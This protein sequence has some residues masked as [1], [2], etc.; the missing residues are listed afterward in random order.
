MNE[1]MMKNKSPSISKDL[2]FIVKLYLQTKIESLKI[3]SKSYFETNNHLNNDH[4]L[5]QHKNDF[6][7]HL[8]VDNDHDL[9]LGFDSIRFD[10]QKGKQTAMHQEVM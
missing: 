3:S 5:K 1:E 6:V 8:Q 4:D 10:L 9:I 7:I 2:T